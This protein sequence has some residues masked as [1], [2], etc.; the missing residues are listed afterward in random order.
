ALLERACRLHG[1][2]LEGAALPPPVERFVAHYAGTM[3]GRTE[4]SPGLVA[5]LARL[6]SAGPRLSVCP[7]TLALLALCLLSPLS[8]PL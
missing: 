2:P 1:P 5:A 6:R 7:P 3:P 8:L 4:P